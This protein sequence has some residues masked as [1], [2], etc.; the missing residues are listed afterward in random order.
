MGAVEFVK[1]HGV[2]LASA[3]GPVPN[4]AEWIAKGAIK[5]SWWG[6]P[7]GREI[8]A[9]L[10]QLD[11]SDDVVCLRL[12]LGKLSFAHRRVWPAL[13]ALS[14]TLGKKRLARIQQEHTASG[15]HKNRVVAFPKW[16]PKDV[17][18]AGKKLSPEKARAVLGPAID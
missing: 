17:L 18:A 7:R 8:F 1:K 13:V 16:V 9:A 6:H 14:D 5:G 4:V 3:K 12:V 11:D 10:S 2:V 15:A